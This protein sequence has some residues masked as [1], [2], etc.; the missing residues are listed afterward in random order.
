MKVVPISE[1]RKAAG[2]SIN[3]ERYAGS[4]AVL[5]VLSD[6]AIPVDPDKTG[7]S[8]TKAFHDVVTDQA[9]NHMRLAELLLA[10][11]DAPI[12]ILSDIDGTASRFTKTASAARLVG[13]YKDSLVRINN[14]HNLLDTRQN[15]A[16]CIT[17]RSEQDARHI[18]TQPGAPIYQHTPGGHRGV[19]LSENSTDLPVPVIC[20]HGTCLLLPDGEQKEYPL[21]DEQ[22]MFL[23]HAEIVAYEIE[24]SYADLA[25]QIKH[26]G[27]DIKFPD[28]YNYQAVERAKTRLAELCDQDLNPK[29]DGGKSFAVH[30]EGDFEVSIR[31]EKA[32]KAAAI[33][34][35]VSEI[36]GD[37]PGAMPVYLGD[38]FAKGGTDRKAAEYVQSLGG[39]AIQVLNG[40]PQNIPADHEGFR[41]DITLPN[42]EAASK[43]LAYIT[44]VLENKGF[45]P[46]MRRSLERKAD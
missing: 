26:S 24:R 31:F 28:T 32:D 44:T 2:F 45:S 1:I 39:F 16:M 33:D 27:I 10:V 8:S 19:L 5:D 3:V 23:S 22:K 36:L 9:Q 30:S 18:L 11:R 6:T 40:R 15:V 25:I 7:L 14:A 17:G 12:L 46:A 35:F 21:T 41:P 34:Y 20:S 38:S 4:R 13:G 42:P 37:H 43:L 29:V